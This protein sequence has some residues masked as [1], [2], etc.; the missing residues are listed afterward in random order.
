M[1]EYKLIRSRR[2]TIGIS[3]DAEG[4]VIVRAPQLSTK[5]QIEKA[6]R[7]AEGWIARQRARLQAEAKRAEEEAAW[8]K[9]VVAETTTITETETQIP[10]STEETESLDVRVNGERAR[11]V[12]RSRVS[13]AVFGGGRHTWRLALAFELEKRNGSWVFIKARASTY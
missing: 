8:E 11:L 12:G 5:A 2:K 4:Q 6:L 7:E 3:V 9:V 10:E 13:A 1:T